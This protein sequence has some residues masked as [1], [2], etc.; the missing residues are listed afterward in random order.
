MGIEDGFWG[1][2]Q[3]R[4][5]PPNNESVSNIR[6]LGDTILGTNNCVSP[7]EYHVTVSG[8]TETRDV[9][10]L[11]FEHIEHRE[12]DALVLIGGDGS[13]SITECCSAY[14]QNV[15]RI[16][17]ESSAVATIVRIGQIVACLNF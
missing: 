1:L 10:D 17:M 5:R 15:G 12:L 4:M 16:M 13:M 2:I 8:V 7:R 9:T 3:Y 6:T 11:C 14:D